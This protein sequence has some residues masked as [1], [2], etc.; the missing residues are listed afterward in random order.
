MRESLP[1]PSLSPW[2][3]AEGEEEI[4]P[5]KTVPNRPAIPAEIS[6]QVFIEAG[7]RCAVCGTPM[8]LERAHIIPWRKTQDHSLKNLICLCANCHARADDED[9]GSATLQRYKEK[10]WVMRN[11]EIAEPRPKLTKIQL[12]IDMELENFTDKNQDWLQY[13]LA[14]FLQIPPNAVNIVAMEGGSVKVTVEIPEKSVE[15]LF[16]AWKNNDARLESYLAPFILIDL[17]KEVAEPNHDKCGFLEI[18]R[19]KPAAFGE[20][21]R[22]FRRRSDLSQWEI[23][24]RL[25][26][27]RGYGVSDS[28]VASWERGYRIPVDAEVVHHLAALLSLTREEEA[29][30]VQLWGLA[31]LLPSL[32]E[33]LATASFACEYLG[34]R[35]VSVLSMDSLRNQRATQAFKGQ[36]SALGLSVLDDLYAPA[37]TSDFKLYLHQ[38]AARTPDV[39]YT[40]QWPVDSYPSIWKAGL[41]IGL[42]PSIPVIAMH[43]AYSRELCTAFPTIPDNLYVASVNKLPTV[44]FYRIVKDRFQP[45]ASVRAA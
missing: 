22:H 11:Y 23:A 3:R 7:H 26:S 20:F 21:V 35:T 14:A 25:S 2:V 41:E 16:E 10:P 18:Y 1:A 24:D 5:R 4:K 17:Q 34:A 32:P 45:V 27:E 6:R 38:I 30:L 40:R 39:L 42:L 13:A 33:Y 44:D 8:P 36:M 37:D 43:N 15:K 12:T 19:N 31:K 28:S 29:L 9:W